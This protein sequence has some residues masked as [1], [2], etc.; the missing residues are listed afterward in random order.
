M[1]CN[2]RASATPRFR[3]RRRPHR[4]RGITL[5]ELL[6][7]IGVVVVLAALL[8]PAL[9]AVRSAARRTQ[10]GNNLNHRLPIERKA[11]A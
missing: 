1:S 10:C 4:F 2:R 6:V 3:C 7:S 8:M 5:V 9:A 11:E